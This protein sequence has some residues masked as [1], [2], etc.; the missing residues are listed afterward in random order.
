M[1][2]SWAAKVHWCTWGAKV[3]QIT[4]EVNAGSNGIRIHSASQFVAYGAAELQTAESSNNEHVSIRTGPRSN[5]RR[6][7]G[8][9]NHVFFN[10]TW[11]ARCVCSPGEH[12]APR[13]TMGRRQDG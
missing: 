10:I 9:L 8:L 13:C 1:T 6:W 11:M 7:P 2:E 12:M 3:V 5:G 4:E